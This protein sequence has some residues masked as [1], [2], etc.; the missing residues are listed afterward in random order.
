VCSRQSQFAFCPPES[1]QLY[2]L[3]AIRRVHVHGWRQNSV[4]AEGGRIGWS[5]LLRL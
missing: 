1:R 2:Y 5:G 3:A 4:V